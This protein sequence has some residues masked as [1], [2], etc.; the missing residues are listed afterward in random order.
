MLRQNYMDAAK[1]LLGPNFVIVP[2]FKSDPAQASELQQA[3]AAPV[4]RRCD[5]PS[6]N[7][8]TRP[9]ASGRASRI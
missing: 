5:R 7:G 9:L 1:S 8:C 4:S 3:L 2:L 6:R